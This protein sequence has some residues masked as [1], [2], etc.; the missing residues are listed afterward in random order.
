MDLLLVR[1]ADLESGPR[2]AAEELLAT[3]DAGARD[4]MNA[5]LSERGQRHARRMANWL[6]QH[7]PRDLQ[8][9]SSPAKA[10]REMAGLFAGSLGERALTPVVSR[11]LGPEAHATDLLGAVGWPDDHRAALLI[12]HQPALGHLAGLLL[13]GQEAPLAFKKGALWWFAK[14]QRGDQTQTVL[15]CVL[16]PDLMKGGH[17]Q[18]LVDAV[19]PPNALAGMMPSVADLMRARFGVIA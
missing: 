7:A 4:P 13:S 14:R 18:D 5:G 3:Q 2:N 9:F 17:R 15:R 6:R 19:D 1:C 8:I 10:G 16:T 12:A 11:L